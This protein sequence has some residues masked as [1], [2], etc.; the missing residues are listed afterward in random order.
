MVCVACDIYGSCLFYRKD[1]CLGHIDPNA[2]NTVWNSNKRRFLPEYLPFSQPVSQTILAEAKTGQKKTPPQGPWGF[3]VDIFGAGSLPRFTRRLF[4]RWHFNTARPRRMGNAGSRADGP[5]WAESSARRTSGDTGAA[6][7][8]YFFHAFPPAS[9]LWCSFETKLCFSLVARGS[10]LERGDFYWATPGI[11]C[12]GRKCVKN[13]NDMVVLG[14]CC[15]GNTGS[16]LLVANGA[17]WDDLKM[18]WV[19]YAGTWHL[20][21][22]VKL[23]FLFSFVQRE[24]IL[25]LSTECVIIGSF[26]SGSCLQNRSRIVCSFIF[27]P[28][29]VWL[30]VFFYICRLHKTQ[31]RVQGLLV[32]STTRCLPVCEQLSGFCLWPWLRQMAAKCRKADKGYSRGV[33]SSKRK[34]SSN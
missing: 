8:D 3:H 9:S 30:F 23:Y 21:R 27:P 12:T 22:M 18:K 2:S 10:G 25:A 7:A 16:R 24:C 31:G 6:I 15:G 1:S 5:P 19:W 17:W 34:N 14:V 32:G 11:V 28:G 4:K 26:E 20:K 29:L 33:S 13:W